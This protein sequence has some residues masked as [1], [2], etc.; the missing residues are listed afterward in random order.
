MPHDHDESSG[1]EIAT[2]EDSRP[3]T[4]T[5]LVPVVAPGGHLAETVK[6]VLPAI[7][8]DA[9]EDAVT[10]FAEYFTANIRNP[11][12]RRAYFRNA[13]SF[14]RWCE[15]RGVHELGANRP[16][17]VAAYI[18]QLQRTHSK[19]SVKQQF[20]TI[21]MLFDWLVTGQINP[22]NPAHAV[23]GPKHVVT[24]GK[25]SILS[26]EETRTLFESI[27]P[28]S[29]VDKRDRAVHRRDVLYLCSRGSRGDDGS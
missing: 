26:P 14:L 27:R 9:G 20:A 8:T 15:G 2:I 5:D 28:E 6:V 3:E 1:T 7:V 23:R 25:T 12:T 22:L 17:L 11:H 4:S 16:M 18:E 10:R 29:V 24:K 21:R 19:P 13:M